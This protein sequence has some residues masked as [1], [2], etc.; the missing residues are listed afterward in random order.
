MRTGCDLVSGR[1][2]KVGEV[3]DSGTISYIQSS[4][5]LD[6]AHERRVEIVPMS[7]DDEEHGF[8]CL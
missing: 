5:T 6:S 2:E 4:P 7:G 3:T 1:V 8:H